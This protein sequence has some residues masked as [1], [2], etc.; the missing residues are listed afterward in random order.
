MKIK[1]QPNLTEPVKLFST[2][3]EQ[4][5]E[6]LHFSIEYEKAVEKVNL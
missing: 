2:V 3:N 6:Y 1:M 4:F 5:D